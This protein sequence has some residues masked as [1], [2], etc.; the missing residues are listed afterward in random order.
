MFDNQKTIEAYESLLFLTR[1]KLK[2]A[3]AGDKHKIL[4]LENRY[5]SQIKSIKKTGGFAK[6]SGELRNKKLHLL[7]EILA[8]DKAI[9]DINDPWLKDLFVPT[10]DLA[11]KRVDCSHYPY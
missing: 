7:N 1:K 2:A 6:L 8:I 10:A 11:T 4:A 3:R 5:D 9:R